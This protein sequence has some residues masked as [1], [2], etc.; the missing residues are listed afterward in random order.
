[1]AAFFS[2][3]LELPHLLLIENKNKNLET[4]QNYSLVL[5]EAEGVDKG[6]SMRVLRYYFVPLCIFQAWRMTIATD[7]RLLTEMVY[8]VL[9]GLHIQPQPPFYE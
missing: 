8:F 4:V 9:Y 3:P 7:V 5:T 6:M 2:S 1:M